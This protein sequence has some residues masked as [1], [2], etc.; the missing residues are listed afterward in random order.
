MIDE[1]I[2]L[3]SRARSTSIGE[4][5]HPAQRSEEALSIS[6]NLA[7][8]GDGYHVRLA[9]GITH[10]ETQISQL[11]SRM[12]GSRGLTPAE[13]TTPVPPRPG[14]TS[15]AACSGDRVVG[16]LTVGV[17]SG[18]GLLADTLYRQQ[19]DEVRETGGRVCEVTRLAMDSTARSSDLM[20]TLFS[21]GFILARHVHRMTDMFIEV[22]PRHAGYYQ[23]MLGYRVS[24]P[25]LICPR[26]QAPAVLMHL[27][28]DHAEMRLRHLAA[29]PEARERSLYR[30]VLQPGEHARIIRELLLQPAAAA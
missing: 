28:L 19:I 29:S 17:D 5:A 4:S 7:I 8:I 11:V 15:L 10:L 2:H 3:E 12:Y 23:K 13:A 22:H 20:G 1:T 18:D 21:L 9:T 26:V 16:T 14:Q 25:L 30:Q 24:G 27:P 6:R